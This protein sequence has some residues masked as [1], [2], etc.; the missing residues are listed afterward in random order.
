LAALEFSHFD[1]GHS[2]NGVLIYIVCV[3]RGLK[4]IFVP[5]EGYGAPQI[6]PPQS[7]GELRVDFE[8]VF[9][10][11]AASSNSLDTDGKAFDI[12]LKIKLNNL[13]KVDKFCW[14]KPFFL[15]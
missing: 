11:K 4:W 7:S 5:F 8:S 13:E 2:S 10:T 14:T 12:S 1:T 6:P 3:V 15:M 9:G